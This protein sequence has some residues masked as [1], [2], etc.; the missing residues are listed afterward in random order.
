[1]DYSKYKNTKSWPKQG[2]ENAKEMWDEH[3]AE[4]ERLLALFWS[5]LSE[6][7]DISPDHPKYSL[8]ARLAWD[9][10]HSAGLQDVEYYFAEFIELVR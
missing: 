1:M 7:Y 6:E 5:D 9:H 2:S 3:H 10:G 8:L 4:Q